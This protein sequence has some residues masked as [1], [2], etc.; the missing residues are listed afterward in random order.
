L[1]IEARS[2]RDIA[3]PNQVSWVR[4]RTFLKMLMGISLTFG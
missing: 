1:P 2:K 4:W 3:R